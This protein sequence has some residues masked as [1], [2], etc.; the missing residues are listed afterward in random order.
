MAF[1]RKLLGGKKES[2]TVAGAYHDPDGI[3]FY[4]ECNRC[5]TCV[6]VRADRRHDLNDAEGG[7]VWHKT[8]VDSRCFQ[9]MQTVVR[10]DR[11]YNILS[12]EIEGGRFVTEADYNSFL[13]KR[14]QSA[15]ASAAPTTDRNSALSAAEP[16]AGRQQDED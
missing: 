4:A 12:A 13:E 3:Y 9:R 6:R 10:F 14:A 8:I 16:D 2:G 5:H 15:P 1:L 11:G 7:Y